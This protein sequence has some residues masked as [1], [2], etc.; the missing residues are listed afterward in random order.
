MPTDIL[1]S[2]SRHPIALYFGLAALVVLVVSAWGDS[3][4]EDYAQ[5][6]EAMVSKGWLEGNITG[7]YLADHSLEPLNIRVS[8]EGDTAV[9]GG[10]TDSAVQKDLAQEIALSVEGIAKV[11]NQLRVDPG[12]ALGNRAFSE[13][14]ETSSDKAVT[15]RVRTKLLA[16]SHV[17]GSHIDVTTVEGTVT[18]SGTVED[19]DQKKLIYFI[20]RNTD[21]VRFIDSRIAI[22]EKL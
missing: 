22:S 3:A 20:T 8:V 15:A 21:G 18:L 13:T 12:R 6:I 4:P 9:L 10:T 16:N 2:S 5:E 17:P 19:R 11:D 14:G 7:A 1:A